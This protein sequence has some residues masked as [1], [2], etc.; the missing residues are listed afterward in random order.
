MAEELAGAVK[1]SSVES[2]EHVNVEGVRAKR[3]LIAG[4]DGTNI[5]DVKVGVD[6]TLAVSASIDT[7]G[8]ATSAKQLADGH[9]VTV[10]NSTGAAAVNIQDGGNTITVDG[11]VSVNS[12]A[13]T[14]AGTFATQIDGSALTALQLIDDI[15]GAIKGSGSPTIDSYTQ[16]AINLAAGNDQ[17]LVASAANKQVWVYGLAF[18]TDVAGTVSFQ[19][20]DN[21]AISGIMNIDAKGGIAIAPSGNFAMPI[22]KL[23]T[24]KDLEVDVVTAELDGFLTYAIVSV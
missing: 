22:W 17:V 20:E 15:V 21:T 9:N 1:P 23:A 19:D 18:T 10:D 14:N 13:V 5:Q 4:S 12:H 3:V 6:G 11:T 24:D 2:S 16:L 8:L 7:T